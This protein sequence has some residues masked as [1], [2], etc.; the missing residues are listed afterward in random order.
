MSEKPRFSTVTVVRWLMESTSLRGV[1]AQPAT[2]APMTKA[3]IAVRI[4]RVIR[5]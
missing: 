2:A 5:C 1:E 3:V 4:I